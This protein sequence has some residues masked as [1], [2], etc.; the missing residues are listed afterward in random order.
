MLRK[1]TNSLELEGLVI[2]KKRL[3]I[4]FNNIIIKMHKSLSKKP[5]NQY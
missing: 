2:L 1:T 4:M 5:L 3:K